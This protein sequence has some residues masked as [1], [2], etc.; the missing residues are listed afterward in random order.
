MVRLKLGWKCIVNANLFMSC[1][2]EFAIPACTA[3]I[4]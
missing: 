1:L 3:G 2:G 4:A